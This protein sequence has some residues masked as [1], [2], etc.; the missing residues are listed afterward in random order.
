MSDKRIH[1]IVC[2]PERVVY[3]RDIKEV[4]VPTKAGVTGILPK[5]VG[6]VSVLDKGALHI[7]H[8]EGEE[9][10]SIYKGVLEVRPE[11]NVVVLA[12]SA[13]HISEMSEEAIEQAKARVEQ[14]MKEEEGRDAFA[15]AR[16][17]D[18]LLREISHLNI[19]R[20]YRK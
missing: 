19:A 15:Y 12:D 6:L 9:I 1:I 2:T 8:D 17:E 3:E 16:F 13:D 14:A 18:L 7:K 10:L 4:Y 20:K 11:S 5:H